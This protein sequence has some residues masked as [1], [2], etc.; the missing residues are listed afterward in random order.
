MTSLPT[1]PGFYW[2][3]ESA[4][5][6]Y[7]MVHIIDFGDGR[8]TSYDVQRA[9]WGGR[10]LDAWREH[11]PIGEWQRILTPEEVADLNQRLIDRTTGMQDLIQAQQ[12]EI[13]RWKAAH[14]EISRELLRAVAG[15]IEMQD[16]DIMSDSLVAACNCLT[17][18]PEVKYHKPG[19]KYRLISER[20]AARQFIEEVAHFLFNCSPKPQDWGVRN[21]PRWA[22]LI[23][24]SF[25][26]TSSPSPQV[27]PSP[28]LASTP[29]NP[30]ASSPGPAGSAPP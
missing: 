20:D 8:L 6:P 11:F 4:A 9:A 27:S 26:F 22:E 3:R 7:R 21:G 5:F 17:K 24:D 23:T 19:C 16:P 18:T 28:S 12:L 2:W 10:S 1:L 15:M 30:A 13:A 14:K 29:P 25:E